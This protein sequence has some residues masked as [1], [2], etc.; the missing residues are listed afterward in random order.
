MKFNNHNF[1]GQFFGLLLIIM[2]LLFFFSHKHFFPFLG[3]LPFD[4]YW[5]NKSGTVK[6]F[7]PIG[8]VLVLGL[9]ISFILSAVLRR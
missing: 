9:I 1:D 5:E 2:G 6:A 8:S 7:L 4:F 3:N